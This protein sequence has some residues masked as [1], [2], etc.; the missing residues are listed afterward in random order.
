MDRLSERIT[1]RFSAPPYYARLPEGSHSL[2][3]A[4]PSGEGAVRL[5]EGCEVFELRT[6]NAE[7]A[8]VLFLALSG[9][10]GLGGVH[11]IMRRAEQ[12]TLEYIGDLFLLFDFVDSFGFVVARRALV[13]LSDASLIAVAKTAWRD[14][15]LRED[16]ILERAAG[17]P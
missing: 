7:E 1:L 16:R 17:L 15:S 9:G 4:G 8:E 5:P 13:P 11:H 14:G 2:C 12:I 3:G 10:G 6:E